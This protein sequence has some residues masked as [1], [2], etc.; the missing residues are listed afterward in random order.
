MKI[1]LKDF[2]K[3]GELWSNLEAT[4]IT[5]K[6]HLNSN[7]SSIKELK[8]RDLILLQHIKSLQNENAELKA[9]I[10]QLD[11]RLWDLSVVANTDN[12]SIVSESGSRE[13]KIIPA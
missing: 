2:F 13:M 1:S 6:K 10:L 12:I 9:K 5:I 3:N 8:T 7:T 11:E 4:I